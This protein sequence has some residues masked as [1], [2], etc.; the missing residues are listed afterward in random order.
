MGRL[1]CSLLPGFTFDCS[2]LCISPWCGHRTSV[3][4]ALT[5]NILDALAETFS[6][7]D[8]DHR[9][10]MWNVP[11]FVSNVEKLVVASILGGVFSGIRGSIVTV[12]SC[13]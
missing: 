11:G 2:G 4:S 10:S 1:D 9:G 13:L 6:H 8:D 3:Y 12:V 5:G 7:N